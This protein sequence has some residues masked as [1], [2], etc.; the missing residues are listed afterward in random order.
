[1]TLWLLIGLALAD[2]PRRPPLRA[3]DGC[4]PPAEPYLADVAE[5]GDET[6]YHCLIRTDAFYEPLVAAVRDAPDGDTARK[7]W[8]RALSLWLIARS[9][10]PFDPDVVRLLSADDRRLISDG[11][12]ARR[13]RK[14]ASAEHDAIFR[15]QWWYHVDP[16]YTDNKLTAVER[17]NIAIADK[18]PPA[19]KATAPAEP[20]VPP[21]PAHATID[22][23]PSACGCATPSGG[24]A[25]GLAGIVAWLGR[26]R[27][28][29]LPRRVGPADNAGST[30][31][32]A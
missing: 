25:T 6:S 19:A 29:G 14:S 23:P 30:R 17:D 9:T 5:R 24:G 8:A 32:P 27:R 31:G 11:V 21:P 20:L 1:M 28:P 15:K 18:P 4:E 26:R 10:T 13:G 22:E 3:P 16:G 7:R 12:R 2:D